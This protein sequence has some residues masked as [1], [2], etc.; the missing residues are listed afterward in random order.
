MP[1]KRRKTVRRPKRLDRTAMKKREV[2]IIKDLK[3]G[4]LSYRMIAEKHKVSLPTVNAKA[5]K[6]N[7]SRPRGRRPAGVKVVKMSTPRRRT[8]TR[9]PVVRRAKR[10]IARRTATP[11]RTTRR[12]AKGGHFQDAFREMVLRYY[13][14]ITLKKFDRLAKLVNTAVK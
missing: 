6:A 10:V 14:S 1:T 13:P 11:K 9:K 3:A 8:T 5:R 7:I 12:V 4:K 2:A